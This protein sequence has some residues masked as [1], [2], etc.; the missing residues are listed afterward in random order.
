MLCSGGLDQEGR[1]IM[2]DF[3]IPVDTDSQC[4]TFCPVNCGHNEHHCSKGMDENGCEDPGWCQ[5][6]EY[7]AICRMDCPI[8]CPANE[9]SCNMGK[10][11]NGCMLETCS[12]DGKCPDPP[13]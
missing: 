6:Y 7:S 13:M 1:P 5:P 10:D 4:P 3:C 2:Q 12:Q 11:N 9:S 8:N